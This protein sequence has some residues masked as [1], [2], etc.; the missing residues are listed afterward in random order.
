[1]VVINLLNLFLGWLPR[2]FLALPRLCLEGAPGQVRPTR[3]AMPTPES[4][5]T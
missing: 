3:T 1:M 5:L 4:L 2:V